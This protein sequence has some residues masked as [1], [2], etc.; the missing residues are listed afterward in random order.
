MKNYLL[1][2]ILLFSATGGMNAQTQDVTVLEMHPAPGQFVNTLPEWNE[3]E[4]HEDICR[5]ATESLKNKELLH[6]GTYGGYMTVKFDHPIRNLR[7]SDLRITGNGFYAAADPVYGKETIGGSFEPGIVYVGVGDDVETAQWYELA[8]CM[9]NKGQIHDFSI[10]YYKPTAETGEHKQP[11]SLY[12]D[13]IRWEAKWTEN[14]EPRDSTGYHI[15][16][17]FHKQSYWPGWENA[18]TLT[19]KGGKLPNNAIDQS[20]KG[21]YWVLYRYAKDA[22]GYVDDSLNDDNYSTFDIDWAV[23]DNGNPVALKEINF[24]RVM[25]GIF[26]VCG[27]LGE[28]S[29]EV[30]GFTD[31]HLVPGY[32]DDPI[33]IGPSAATGFQHSYM[34]GNDDNYYDLMGR[35]VLNPTSG[36]Y[37][38]KGRK[39]MIR[40]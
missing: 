2:G 34:Y 37:I 11:Y 22:Y 35:I 3:G 25:T 29:T 21:T 23:D 36:I 33:I 12:D 28:T 24:I 31:L 8:G 10:T 19:F 27:W 9:Y 15:K 1:S 16:N 20:G 40:N 4:T 5:K 13:Y 30:S 6:L 26:Q 17:S 39:I 32:D 18:E 38:H 14:G 7:G